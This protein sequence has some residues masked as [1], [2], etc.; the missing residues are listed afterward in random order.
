MAV[1]MSLTSLLVCA[2]AP[3][4]QV[5]TRILEELDIAVETCGD[6][7]MAQA[8]LEDRRFDAILLECKN[9]T[10]ALE[11]I[12]HV[13]NQTT[14]QT[15]VVIAIVSGSNDVRQIFSKGA[16]FALYKP[17]SRERAA[18]SMRAARSL[19]QSERRLRPRIA[20]EAKASIAYSGKEDVPAALVD[21]SEEGMALRTGSK[22]PPACKVYFQFSLPGNASL[23]RLSGEVMWQDSAGRAGIR[24]ADV[25]QVSRRVL[26]N[27]LQANVTSLPEPEMPGSPEV[28]VIDDATERLSAGLGLL[29]VSAGDRRDLS[30]RRCCLGVEVYRPN[31]SAPT[32][33]TLIDVSSGG[34][35]VE[36]SETFPTETPLE[37]VV[38]T[39]NLKLRILGKVQSMHPGYGMGIKFTLRS[40]EHRQKVQQLI[41]CAHSESRLSI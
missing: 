18:H 4:V 36:S 6:L 35:Y 41:E 3:A 25:P 15:T 17:L 19:M 5:L 14:N 22:L 34:C 27:W 40:D 33:C 10:A 23:V 31:I 39:E 9:E 24:F 16:N 38:R 11:L 37:L 20:V 8:R 26:N 13:R 30:R 32:R 12:L 1:T 7:R 29:S 28:P 21:L 2:D